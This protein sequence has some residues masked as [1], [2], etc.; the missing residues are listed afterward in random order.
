MGRREKWDT[1]VKNCEIGGKFRG[2]IF[3]KIL[4]FSCVGFTPGAFMVI[5]CVGRHVYPTCLTTNK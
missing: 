4:V 2:Y 3:L 1:A 5:V